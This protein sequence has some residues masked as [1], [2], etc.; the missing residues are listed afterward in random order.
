MVYTVVTTDWQSSSDLLYC[1]G[2]RISAA[3]EKKAGVPEKAKMSE[4][5]AVTASVKEGSPTS[6]KSL[7]KG[8]VCGAAAGRA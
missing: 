7:S 2:S 5:I 4:E 3:M 8:P 6:W 1:V